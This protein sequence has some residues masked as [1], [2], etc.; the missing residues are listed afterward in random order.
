MKSSMRQGQ[1]VSTPRGSSGTHEVQKKFKMPSSDAYCV[2]YF[3]QRCKR[4]AFIG[5]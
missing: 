1:G 4:D 2:G 5:L 3:P